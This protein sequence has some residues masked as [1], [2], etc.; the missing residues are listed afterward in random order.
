L[1]DL[2][3]KLKLSQEATLILS[4]SCFLCVDTT[5]LFFLINYFTVKLLEHT[6]N[7]RTTTKGSSRAIRAPRRAPTAPSACARQL[8]PVPGSLILDFFLPK[9]SMPRKI[10]CFFFLTDIV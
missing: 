10:N 4:L 7:V 2:K 9:L 5:L 8:K 6:V 3:V 1:L